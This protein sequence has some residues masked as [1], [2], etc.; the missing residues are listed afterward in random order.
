MSRQNTLLFFDTDHRTFVG[1]TGL[2]LYFGWG[3]TSICD[4]LNL[5]LG[6]GMEYPHVACIRIMNE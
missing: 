4:G 2:D 3:G 1:G 5:Y 6:F